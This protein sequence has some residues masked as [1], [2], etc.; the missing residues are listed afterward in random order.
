MIRRPPRST[1][2]RSSAASDVYKRQRTPAVRHDR[3]GGRDV[4]DRGASTGATPRGDRRRADLRRHRPD[5]A[6]H[7]PQAMIGIKAEG[8]LRVLAD[9]LAAMP[10]VA[11][12]VITA[13]TFDVLAEVICSGDEQLLEILNDQVRPL[14]GVVATETFVYLKV[15]KQ[16]STYHRP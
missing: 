14:P 6:G 1:Q 7:D 13:G 5:P 16:L 9:A 10:E 2:S 4:G 8:D 15:R 11:Y 3:Q 12:V